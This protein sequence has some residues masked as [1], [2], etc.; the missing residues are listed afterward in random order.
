MSEKLIQEAAKHRKR[1]ILVKKMDKVLQREV[2]PNSQLHIIILT[3][4]V[5][6]FADI[7]EEYAA[8]EKTQDLRDLATLIEQTRKA[9]ET[10]FQC[11]RDKMELVAR[12]WLRRAKELEK[13]LDDRV[14]EI[15]TP[16]TKLF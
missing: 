8:E 12:D 11:R 7:A 13:M 10:Y 16:Q 14:K 4:C 1:Q 6:D 15:L 3:N 9:Q 2:Q 5:K